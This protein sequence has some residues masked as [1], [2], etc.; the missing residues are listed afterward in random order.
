MEPAAVVT[1]LAAVLVILALA[2]FLIST[3][4]ELIKIN[5]GLDVVLD[6]V[7]EIIQK[8]APVNEVAGDINDRLARG[9]D[10]LEGLL[11]KKAGVEDAAGV[12]DSVFPGAGAAVLARHGRAGGKVRHI[13]EVYSRGAVQLARLGR[14]APIGAARVQGPAIR[15]PRY[16]TDSASKLYIRPGGAR[17][18]PRSPTIGTDAPVVYDPSGGVGPEESPGRISLREPPS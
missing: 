5:R 13:G 6:A 7:D 10:L 8:T 4:F 15:N 1:I 11:I 3:I 9:R 17:E 14:G 2:F 12:V 16:A 18:R